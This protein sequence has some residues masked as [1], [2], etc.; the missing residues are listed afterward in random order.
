MSEECAVWVRVS[1]IR[2]QQTA[3]QE[4]DIARLT[5]HRGYTEVARYTVRDSGWEPGPEYK[6]ELARLLADAHAGRF[7]VVVV[8][9]ADR[10]SREGIEPL[11]RIVRT[12]R[13]SGVAVVSVQEP[14]LDTT[15]PAVAELLLAI[16]AWVAQQESARR[17]ERTRAGMARA[18]AQGK[19]I[20][21]RQP[22]AKDKRPRKRR[23]VAAA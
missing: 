6:R 23:G 15:N 8:W 16:M 5:A 10:L 4:P 9:A 18:K 2:D 1:D 21:G 12:L 20:G 22:G 7:R 3:N 17:S 14:W 11:L 13:Q 19:R